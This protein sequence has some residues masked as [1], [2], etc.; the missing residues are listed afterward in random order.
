MTTT[1]SRF[2]TRTLRL[3]C[4][5]LSFG[6]AGLGVSSSLAAEGVPLD[7]RTGRVAPDR[8]E[9]LTDPTRAMTFADVSSPKLREAVPAGGVRL[10]RVRTPGTTPRFVGG[11]SGVPNLGFLPGVHWFRFSVVSRID[12]PHRWLLEIA[13]PHLDD[14]TL[15]RVG[16]AEPVAVTGRKLLFR[17]RPIPHHHFLL[18]LDLD[19]GQEATFYLRVHTEG[20][21]QLPVYLHETSRFW[22]RD[23]SATYVDGVY[24]G[25][26]LIMILFNAFLYLGA[27]E[28]DYLFYTL[29][30]LCF[31]AWIL[32]ITG[33]SYR[34]LF[35]NLPEIGRKSLP[36]SGGL[37][38]AFLLVFLGRF[39]ETKD[40]HRVFHRLFWIMGTA[41]GLLVIATFVLSYSITIRW[42]SALMMLIPPIIIAA[43][44]S[45]WARGFGPARYIV[46]AWSL[47]L[48]GVAIYALKTAGVLSPSILTEYAIQTGSAA[49]VAFL[50]FALADR[51]NVLR[52][53][54]A[55]AQAQAIR[56][57]EQA[58]RLKDEFLANTSHELRTPLNGIIGLA[59]FIQSAI[60]GNTRV[61]RRTLTD[62]VAMIVSSSRRLSSLVNDILDFS[63]IKNSELQLRLSSVDLRAAAGLAVHLTAPLA[64]HKN[65]QLRMEVAGDLPPVRA[66]ED[67]LQQILLNLLNNAVKFTHKGEV[68]ISAAPEVGAEDAGIVVCVADTGIGIPKEKQATIFDSFQQGDGSVQR[69][70]GGTGLG[71]SIVRSLLRL[72]GSD[73]VVESEPGKGSRFSFVLPRADADLPTAPAD[74]VQRVDSADLPPLSGTFHDL[75]LPGLS[76]T[77]VAARE[78]AAAAIGRVLPGAPAEQITVLVVDD[79][80]VNLKVLENHLRA[81]GFRVLTAADGESALESVRTDRPDVILLDLMMPRMSGLEVCRRVREEHPASLL[82]IIFLSAKNQVYDLV[83]GLESG[84][85]DY[86]TK[87]FSHHELLARLS[88]HMELRN[89]LRSQMRLS[90]QIHRF[91]PSE[92]L[93]LMDRHD[94]AAVRVGDSARMRMTVLF[95]DIRSFTS[96][97]E[98]M[99]EEET[100]RFLNSY[101]RRMEPEIRRYGGFVDKFIGDAVMALFAGGTSS[102]DSS[103]ERAL[104]AAMGM[105]RALVLY[106]QHRA[107]RGYAAID[108]G[109]GLN[110]GELMLGTVGSANRLETTVIG[111]TVNTAA[112]LETLTTYYGVP[113][114][115]GE[116][117]AAELTEDSRRTVR[118]IDT[119]RLKGRNA[120]VRL[121][122]AFGCDPDE[123]VRSKMESK[124]LFESAVQL[125]NADRREE[126][127]KAFE[128]LVERSPGD[129]VARFY[130]DRLRVPV[131][132]V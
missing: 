82:P 97:A 47:F 18:P 74:A 68:T 113:I 131:A 110:T 108:F 46:L 30:L 78:E 57:L 5:S 91:V 66:D 70:Y 11:F 34:Y 89:T 23:T 117:T 122:E 31:T 27:R 98:R 49:G 20:S 123:I 60:D 69:E 75:S 13:Y 121:Y 52:R 56:N 120:E 107:N 116:Q 124:S 1:R 2:I 114:L 85:N 53:E 36:A 118:Q 63:K 41:S 29:F 58:D 40:R 55:D 14:I 65:I 79:E 19:A 51:F 21:V 62:N 16:Q 61:S 3:L 17:N 71:L 38:A 106:N 76:A 26:L 88:V 67:R 130:L 102:S 84:A 105:R 12:R 119:V 109:T 125:A 90:Q 111:D 43:S 24:L 128:D 54:R 4:S 115:L 81:R 33:H 64:V 101:L 92:F 132:G 44:I 129:Q 77:H 94:V 8:I 104:R 93:E 48:V 99:T 28:R 95:S 22:S 6:A 72:H 73:I 112:R 80:P 100:F 50:S 126:A 42:G 32:S 83:Q 35:G 59:T 10:S 39:L 45:S 96:L 15:F 87:P 86:L 127:R 9:V 7:L 25:L 37:Y 103:S